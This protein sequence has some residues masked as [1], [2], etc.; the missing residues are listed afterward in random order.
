MSLPRDVKE[1]LDGYPN[2][3]NDDTQSAN[4]E[5]YSNRRRCRPDNLLIEEIHDK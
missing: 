4:L 2:N 1:F 5:F 3:H